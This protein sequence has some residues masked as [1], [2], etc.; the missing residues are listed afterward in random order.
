MTAVNEGSD[1]AE[2]PFS[3]RLASTIYERLTDEEDARV[4]RDIPEDAC[5]ETPANFTLM[6][7]A[8]FL[9]KLGDAVANP[10]TVLPW[11]MSSIGAPLYLTGLLVPLR[12]SGSLIPQLFIAGWVRGHSLRKWFWVAGSVL[13]AIAMAAIG[14]VALFASGAFAGW[15]VIAL[16]TAF[17]LARG[18]CSV[19]HK[20]V[21]GKTIPKSKRGQLTGWSASAAGMVTIGL[22]A[23]LMLAAADGTGDPSYGAMIVGAGALWIAAAGLFALVREFPGE[24]GGGGNAFFEALRRLDILRT[25][26]AFRR[27][28]A[29]RALFLSSA[30]SAPYLVVM[31]QENG[32]G[33]AVA[34]GLFVAASGLASMVSGPVW[35][36]LA[37]RSSRKVMVMAASTT[38]TIGFVVFGA[39]VLTPAALMT[40]WFLPLAYFLLSVGHDGVRV[41]RKTY[42]VDLAGGN[43][44]TDYVAVSNS[45]IG[46]LLL[47]GGVASAALGTLGAAAV[48]L[49]LSICGA[50]GALLGLTL[51]EA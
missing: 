31:A 45:I 16:L 23:G 5:R 19:A 12:E 18:L 42:V 46:V 34:L 20:D 49:A 17:S 3:Q 21:L 48:V 33:G 7:A 4:C 1:A 13:Q 10:K 39:A 40:T 6:L 41:G 2:M 27:F 26:A 51:P 30:L 28:V 8:A 14:F 11:V 25:D 47:V 38:A 29:T 32:N 36:R 44:R 9:S 50:A 37:D 35:G 15:A 24:T 43:R 22:G